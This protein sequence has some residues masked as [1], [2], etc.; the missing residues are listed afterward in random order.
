[1]TVD[2]ATSVILVVVSAALAI[3]L[4]VALLDPERF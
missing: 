3:Y 1:M 4:L 2:G